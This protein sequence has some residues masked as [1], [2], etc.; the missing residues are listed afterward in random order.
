MYKRQVLNLCVRLALSHLL[1]ERAGSALSFIV[2]DEVFGALDQVRRNNVLQLLDKLRMRFDQILIITHLDDVKDAVE[3][4]ISI[5]YDDARQELQVGGVLSGM[6]YGVKGQH[7][8]IGW[9]F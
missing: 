5:E 8:S 6:I 3:H 4:I 2:L 7:N 9:N 1:A